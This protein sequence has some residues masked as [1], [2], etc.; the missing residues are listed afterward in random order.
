MCSECKHLQ[1]I[2]ENKLEEAFRP[3]IDL[4]YRDFRFENSWTGIFQNLKEANKAPKKRLM[5]MDSECI[6]ASESTQRPSKSSMHWCCVHNPPLAWKERTEVGWMVSGSVYLTFCVIFRG[7]KPGLQQWISKV[8]ER[9]CVSAGCIRNFWINMAFNGLRFLVRASSMPS[10]RVC[11]C[12]I[13]L[14]KVG[15]GNIERNLFAGER[16]KNDFN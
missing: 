5:E 3:E 2:A 7:L 14:S 15:G 16:K 6:I 9:G 1:F 13:C 10:S 4:F 11:F 12:E 8:W